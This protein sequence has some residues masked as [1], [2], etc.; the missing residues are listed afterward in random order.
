MPT[1]TSLQVSA[2]SLS[3]GQTENLTATVTVAPPNAGTPSGGTVTFLNGSTTLGTATLNSGTATLQVSTLPAGADVVMAN[4]GGTTSFA[5]SSTVSGPNSIITTVAGNGTDGFSGDNGQATAA[6][7]ARPSGV[8]VDANGNLFIVDTVNHRVREVNHATG[9]ITT[10]AGNGT[11]SY[12][13]D[14]GQA[15][16]AGLVYASSVAVDASGHL[17]VADYGGN[18][19]REVNLATGVITTV[20][21]NGT[22][23]YSGDNG[24]ATAAELYEPSGVAVDA[25][26]NLFIADS[27]NERIREVNLA[28]GVITTVAG[29]GA[30]AFGGE[31]GDNGPATAAEL[32]G[33]TGLA[34]DAAGD[35]FIGDYLENRVREVNHATGVIT[36]VAGNGTQSYGGDGGQATAAE[37]DQPAGVAVDANGNL[38]IAD[39]S[40]NR[41]RAVN[42]STGVIT[43][44]AG[45]GTQGSG[46]DNGPATAAELYRP[47]G[48][49]V[50]AAGD[51]LMGGYLENQIR[52]VASGAA[53]VTVKDPWVVAGDGDFNG[54]GTSDILWYNK[55][56][57]NT[58]IWFIQN[59]NYTG[60]SDPGV[61]APST[62]FVVAGIGDFNGNGTSDILWYNTN[63]GNTNIWFIQNGNYTGWSDPGAMA[64]STGFAVAGIGDFNGDG[65]ADILWY[66]KSTGNTNVWFIQNGN[67]TGWSD[68]G[69]MAP[70][71]GFVFAGIGKFNGGNTSDI[72]W[73]NTATGNTNVWFIQNGNYAGW[74]DPGVMAPSTGFAFA[75]VGDFNGDGTTDILWYNPSTG[76][77]N[78]WFIQNG[79]FTGWSDPGVMAPST[80]FVFAAVGD[81][82]GNP[83]LLWYNPTTGNTN[84]WFL[85]N[86]GYTG[87]AD[88]GVI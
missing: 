29:T 58:N 75:G 80:G 8:A 37:L 40:N 63:T 65:T 5:A 33:P 28:T 12:G 79:N 34:V 27:G 25:S 17:F 68:P 56:T 11:Q 48:L 51:V 2:A 21:G 18:R 60:W 85:A 87:F 72:L 7:L 54:N 44:L 77:T 41:I 64:P 67:Y 26:G 23:G 22:Q 15:T 49:A 52:E 32:N 38:F 66:N 13:G 46:G 6:E 36:T 62:G 88:P 16:A 39:S 9:V 50:D 43:T 42:L 76:N 10:V 30:R 69:V 53:V 70:S 20:A 14:G 61:M 4:Y 82:N 31:N 78:V 57:G 81:F 83:D 84:V 19:I 45:T 86:G 59:G 3:S 73:Y 24:Q 71:T 1:S 55:I 35:L 47:S 74:S